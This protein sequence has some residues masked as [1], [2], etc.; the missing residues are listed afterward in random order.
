MSD[1]FRKFERRK[2]GSRHQARAT[3]RLPST[4]SRSSQIL[5][6][7]FAE[8]EGVHTGSDDPPSGR[9]RFATIGLPNYPHV[10]QSFRRKPQCYPSKIGM[11]GSGREPTGRACSSVRPISK[12]AVSRVSCPSKLAHLENASSWQNSVLIVLAKASIQD[13]QERTNVYSPENIRCARDRGRSC[14]N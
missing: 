9:R 7:H 1:D 12:A 14:R 11:L 10:N 8:E 5:S 3:S 6:R 2:Q 13:L 4:R